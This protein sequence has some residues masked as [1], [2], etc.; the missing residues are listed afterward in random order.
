[1]ELIKKIY[2]KKGKYKNYTLILD[3]KKRLSALEGEFIYEPK[4][5]DE[6]IEML[7]EKI[8]LLKEVI[9]ILKENK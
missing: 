8:K 4:T 6:T 5:P 7:N 3:M 2:A 1:M 9:K